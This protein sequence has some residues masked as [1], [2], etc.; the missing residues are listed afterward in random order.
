M[1]KECWRSRQDQHS[2]VPFFHFKG[3]RSFSV[4]SEEPLIGLEQTS[5]M[6]RFH[7]LDRL[8]SGGGIK[9]MAIGN[10]ASYEAVAIIQSRNPRA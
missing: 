2:E 4:Q 1:A 5:D 9:A 8:P 6:I 10:E 7:K 3:F